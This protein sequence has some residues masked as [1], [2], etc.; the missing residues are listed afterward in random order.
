LVA[1]LMA[2]GVA[3]LGTPQ[4]AAASATK[5]VWY[6]NGSVCNHTEGYGTV[7]RWIQARRSKVS[8][9]LICNYSADISVLDGRNPSRV[10]FFRNY[11][12]NG[13]TP[14]L[15]YFNAT[16]NGAFAV[17]DITSVRWYESG[18]DPSGYANV[19]L[20]VY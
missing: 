11:R 14:G 13:C 9:S 16:V 19:V 7:V 18:N 1:V 5:C 17:G 6:P 8:A 2:C 15:A 10:K 4:S 3:I 12:H 20:A